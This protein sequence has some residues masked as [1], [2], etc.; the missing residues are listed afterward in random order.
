M[1]NTLPKIIPI[2]WN[3]AGE[4]DGCGSKI[5]IFLMPVITIFLVFILAIVTKIDPKKQN[6]Q[7]SK[8]YPFTIVLLDL[9]FAAMFVITILS[10]KGIHVNMNRIMPL[11]M[12][13]LFIG[14]GFIIRKM[15]YNYSAGIRLPW[16][17]ANEEV[18]DKAQNMG[19]IV[20]AIGGVAWIIGAFLHMP[21]CYVMPLIVIF[22]GLVVLMVY[23]YLC[24]KNIEDER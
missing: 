18:W 13:I 14:I 17:L 15:P 11:L 20:F 2:H 19:G 7:K 4:I 9:L 24:Y 3:G 23:S 12:G 8:A 16:T 21:W 1:W 5:T 6:L 22:V 10:I